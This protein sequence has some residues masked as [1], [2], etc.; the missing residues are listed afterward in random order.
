M[1]TICSYCKDLK[2]K[3]GEWYAI[4][5]AIDQL[6]TNAVFS[7]GMCSKCFD[8]TMYVMDLENKAPA[9]NFSTI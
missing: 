5:Y 6:P 4:E 2:D 1:F 3:D 9:S 7:H 8:R